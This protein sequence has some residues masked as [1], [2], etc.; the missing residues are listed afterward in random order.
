[1]G[2]T[3]RSPCSGSSPSTRRWRCQGGENPSTPQR[4]QPATVTKISTDRARARSLDGKQPRS[5]H[6]QPKNSSRSSSSSP[7]ISPLIIADA[8]T[9]EPHY[10]SKRV[11]KYASIFLAGFILARGLLEDK[12]L[13]PIPEKFLW[14]PRFGGFPSP[15]LRKPPPPRRAF[16]I[17]VSPCAEKV[18]R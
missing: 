3:P 2:S 14:R 4:V 6:N 1:M 18:T 8:S 13:D 10:A 11:P 9:I 7:R 15:V 12:S 5:Q 16:S 17:F